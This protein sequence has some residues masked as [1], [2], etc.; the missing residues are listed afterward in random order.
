RLALAAG[1]DQVIVAVPDLDV[2]LAC[3]DAV[4]DALRSG[5]LAEERVTGAAERV[6]RLAGRYAVPGEVSGWDAEAGLTAARRAVRAGGRLPEPVPGA[7]VVDC[8]P[9]PHPALNWGGED[10]L[11]EL[12]ALD[13]TATGTPVAGEPGT[14]EN[15]EAAEDVVGRVLRAAQ[16]RPLVVA[17]CDSELYPWQRR[18]RD[19]LLAA[20]PDALLVSTGLPEVDSAVCSYG[21]GRVNLRAV[22]EALTS[23]RRVP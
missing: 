12:R 20:R 18:L 7:H 6:R 13:P 19:A 3:R 21:R 16:G 9:P 10:L 17:V 8:F 14:A 23:R 2:S 11:T 22:A 15:T 5:E 4:L 1:A